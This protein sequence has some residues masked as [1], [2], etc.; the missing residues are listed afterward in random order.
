MGMQ[1]VSVTMCAENVQFTMTGFQP[2][3][4]FAFGFG[5]GKMENSY[6]IVAAASPFS[7]REYVLRE[8]PLAGDQ[9]ENEVFCGLSVES[10][11]NDGL[12]RTV[13]ASRPRQ[14]DAFT[15][16]YDADGGDSIGI[17]MITAKS[18]VYG[19]ALAYHGD[20][21]R[22][23]HEYIELAPQ[24]KEENDDAKK[25]NDR[26]DETKDEKHS[27]KK[28]NSKDKKDSKDKEEKDKDKNDKKDKEKKEKKDDKGGSGGKGAKAAEAELMIVRD[29]S[30][31]EETDALL[32]AAMTLMVA[33]FAMSLVWRCWKGGMK[34]L[35]LSMGD[36][37]GTPLLNGA[38]LQAP[39]NV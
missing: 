31:S 10:D 29:V 23:A 25:D 39:R 6:A 27:E 26:N 3:G 16:P 1:S 12:V 2:G 11:T 32:D 33:A 9:S 17:D 18:N 15:F 19:D 13:V 5:S 34:R 21:N 28:S 30:E 37:A 7:V 38:H 8:K 20:S 22:A 14:C 35:K 24:E 36:P 4:W